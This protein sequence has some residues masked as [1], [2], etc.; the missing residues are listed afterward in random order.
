[1]Q[2]T[3]ILQ[4]ESVYRLLSNGQKPKFF[5][6]HK[7]DRSQ[8]RKSDKGVSVDNLQIPQSRART[9]KMSKRRSLNTPEIEGDDCQR[10]G[11]IISFQ[12][13]YAHRIK[14]RQVVIRS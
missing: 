9:L 5:Q 8:I 7:L 11:T 6:K 2:K 4:L 14:A 13:A 3:F 12:V 1:M 10:N